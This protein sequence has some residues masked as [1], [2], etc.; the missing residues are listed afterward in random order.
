MACGPAKGH[1]PSCGATPEE[2]TFRLKK[3]GEDCE[4]GCYCPIGTVLHEGECINPRKCPCRL[5]GKSFPPGKTISKDCNT[6]SCHEGRWKCTEAACGARCS[7]IGDPHYQTFDG[8]T[9]DFMGQCSYVLMQ[10]KNVSVEAENVACAGAISK[11]MNLPVALTGGMPS[12]TKS[13]TIRIDR[14]QT[15]H[16]KQGREI[17]V[18]GKEVGGLPLFVNGAVIHMASSLFVVGKFTIR[19]DSADVY[20]MEGFILFQLRSKMVWR[21]GGME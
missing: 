12:C 19:S 17:V 3:D 15:L 7:V 5:R 13:L 11:A 20:F 6:C 1:Q 14:G 10:T 18:N 2:L 4:E 21:F 8:R 16:L 9:Y